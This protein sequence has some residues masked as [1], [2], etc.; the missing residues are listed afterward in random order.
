MIHLKRIITVVL[1][2]CLGAC[3][4]RYVEP[5]PFSAVAWFTSNLRNQTF[6]V[7]LNTQ[8]T[9][10]DLSQ[11]ALTHTWKISDGNYFLK[12]KVSKSDTIL[13]GFIDESLGLES[14]EETVHVLFKKAGIQ[15]VQLVNTFKDSVAFLGMDTVYAVREGD[16]WVVQKTFMVDVFEDIVPAI[17]ISLQGIN[18]P[19]SSDTI[20][21]NVGDTLQ[22]VDRTVVG[23]PDTRAWNI[24]GGQTSADSVAKFVWKAP[25]LFTATFVSSR[26]IFNFPPG[27]AKLV[28]PNPIKVVA[29]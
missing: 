11:N 22:M 27:Y 28:I 3:S 17:S 7:G 10:S 6:R 9:F 21:V 18:I 1:L 14:T 16:H 15:T 23:R 24:S 20:F 26:T 13:D 4:S 12:G 29:P 2:A 8:S 5:E 19:L 25:G